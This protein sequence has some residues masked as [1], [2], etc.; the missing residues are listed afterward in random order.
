MASKRRVLG[1]VLGLGLFAFAWLNVEQGSVA[2]ALID[3]APVAKL[4]IIRMSDPGCSIP[5]IEGHLESFGQSHCL[6]E[7]GA[8]SGADMM[9]VAEA[10]LIVLAGV[11]RMPRS[12]GLARRLRRAMF[13]T[14]A[15]LFGVAILDRL[16]LLPSSMTSDV[17]VEMVPFV[18]HG[19]LLQ[20][21]VAFVGVMLMRG[22]KYLESEFSEAQRTRRER[23][24]TNREAFVKVH[25]SASSTPASRLARAPTRPRMT[26]SSPLVRATCP[27]CVGAGCERCDSLG[28]L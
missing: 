12:P 13:A 3:G 15:T 6:G 2:P 20:L 14:G 8:W 22:P 19:W 11:V 17:V 16:V 25:R 1:L 18:N 7:V 24:T 4:D 10:C 9:M 23:V 26:A 27:F 28:T 21:L 5:S